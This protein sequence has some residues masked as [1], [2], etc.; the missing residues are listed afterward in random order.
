MPVVVKGV[1]CLVVISAPL[2]LRRSYQVM[3]ASIF[4]HPLGDVVCWGLRVFWE[5]L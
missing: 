3:A 5:R 2:D 4:I 1:P